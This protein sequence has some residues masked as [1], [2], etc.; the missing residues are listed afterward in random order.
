MSVKGSRSAY[1]SEAM[2]DEEAMDDDEESSAAGATSDSDS[3]SAESNDSRAAKSRGRSVPTV[4][5]DT[6][7]GQGAGRSPKAGAISAVSS[8]ASNARVPSATAAG[9]GSGRANGAAGSALSTR[10]GDPGRATV[11]SFTGENGGENRWVLVIQ[12]CL[13]T[14]IMER[15]KSVTM[16]TDGRGRRSK[17]CRKSVARKIAKDLNF[18]E[19]S[20]NGLLT[21]ETVLTQFTA[22]RG[23][24]EKM[25]N[26]TNLKV[27]DRKL[28][29][30]QDVM[31]S[32][33]LY[34]PGSQ[35]ADAVRKKKTAKLRAFGKGG[36]K[37]RDRCDRDRQKTQK[38]LDEEHEEQDGMEDHQDTDQEGT[39]QEEQDA[40]PRRKRKASSTLQQLQ[41]ENDWSK[42]ITAQLL[43]PPAAMG[44]SFS[45]TSSDVTRAAA[46][47][48]D[49]VDGVRE[50]AEKNGEWC[51][52]LSKELVS[53]SDSLHSVGEES[54]QKMAVL[55]GLLQRQAG[56]VRMLMTAVRRTVREKDVGRTWPVFASLQD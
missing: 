52:A 7:A 39:D 12:A 34:A 15:G 32:D 26:N 56:P 45:Y 14:A 11:L 54:P 40:A 48:E 25:R 10:D 17:V 44:P 49:I 5:K 6:A 55:T 43:E 19:P 16:W 30:L 21:A 8:P 53:I 13:A 31:H 29:L 1:W 51:T 50:V 3:G 9:I 36:S 28:A 18:A 41:D 35:S 23:M 22:A 4:R 24:V 37:L 38:R 47:I 20:F 42:K 2:D 46:L 27:S 33:D